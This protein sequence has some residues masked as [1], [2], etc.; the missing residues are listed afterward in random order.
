M[1]TPACYGSSAKKSQLLEQ[2]RI[3]DED[4]G[5][6]NKED[7]ELMLKINGDFTLSNND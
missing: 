1:C 7:L 2:W 5:G 3:L 6:L 4:Q